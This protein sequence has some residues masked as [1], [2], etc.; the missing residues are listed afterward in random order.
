MKKYLEHFTKSEISKAEKLN[1]LANINT[2]WDD[3]RKFT[4]KVTSDRGIH[5]W[6]RLA[7]IRFDELM[8]KCEDVRTEIDYADGKFVKTYWTYDFK[9]QIQP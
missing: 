8:T 4:K 9:I 5:E 7:E 3:V 1:K 6:Q 2:F